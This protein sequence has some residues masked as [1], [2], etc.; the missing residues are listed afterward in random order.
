MKFNERAWSVQEAIKRRV[1][2]E[3]L[4]RWAKSSERRFTGL[5][6]AYNSAQRHSKP[7]INWYIFFKT[8]VMAFRP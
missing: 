7:H 1:E 3:D 2:I 6:E 8:C 5:L 4:K